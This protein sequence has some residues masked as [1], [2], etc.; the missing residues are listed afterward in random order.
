MP[1]KGTKKI[2]MRMCVG[3]RDMHPK[4]QLVR[5]VRS[6]EGQVSLDTTGKAP[7]RGAY[8]CR[9]SACFQRALKTRAVERALETGLPQDIV[10]R[11]KSELDALG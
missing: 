7:G 2:P 1:A 8:I 5:I 4:K 10:E 3:C 11:L 9:D 6:K